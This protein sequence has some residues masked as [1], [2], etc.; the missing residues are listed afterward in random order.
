MV[1]VLSVIEGQADSQIKTGYGRIDK[2]KAL[3]YGW[4]SPYSTLL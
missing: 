4:L 3:R 1:V 2:Y